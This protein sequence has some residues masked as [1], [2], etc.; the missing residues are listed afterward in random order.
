M[1]QVWPKGVSARYMQL[2]A[3]VYHNPQ[4]RVENPTTKLRASLLKNPQEPS[5]LPPSLSHF[6][7]LDCYPVAD[8][9]KI[10]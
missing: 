4:E 7:P 9:V 6:M 10:L 5:S 8:H 1:I 3:L 2:S